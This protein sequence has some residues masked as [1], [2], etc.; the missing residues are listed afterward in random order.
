[1]LSSCEGPRFGR[2]LETEP[3]EL[4][5]D[6]FFSGC[7][8]LDENANG[9]IDARDSLLGNMNFAVTLASGA[10]FGGK[11]SEG[12]CAFITVPVALLP[13]AWPVLARMVAPDQVA[14]KA[15]GTS[16]V[17]LQYPNTATDFLFA[18]K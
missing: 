17:T 14:Y 5:A 8:Y 9:R 13:G 18:P 2:P 10:G 16:M 4:S 15:V 3:P 6:T 11:T 12:R 7:A 1:M